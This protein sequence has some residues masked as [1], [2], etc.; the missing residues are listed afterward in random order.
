MWWCAIKRVFRMTRNVKG[1]SPGNP[2]Q[3]REHEEEQSV[4]LTRKGVTIVTLLKDK[5]HKEVW[6]CQS[7]S[8]TGRFMALAKL[9]ETWDGVAR[10]GKNFLLGSSS[11]GEANGI[12]K[13]NTHLFQ[14][15]SLC[16]KPHYFPNF[17]KFGYSVVTKKIHPQSVSLTSN[18][19]FCT[20]MSSYLLRK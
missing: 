6:L 18:G 8:G 16:S 1:S 4:T 2:S 12:L 19:K 10:C 9:Q 7:L 5:T 3:N 15:Q 14:I 13:K 20:Q 17:I 11:S